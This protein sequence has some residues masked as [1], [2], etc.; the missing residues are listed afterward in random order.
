MK[1]LWIL[2]T[3]L[4]VA[5]FAGTLSAC[6]PPS[7]PQSS[8]DTKVDPG[9]AVGF[10]GAVS[11]LVLLDELHARRMA[12]MSTA[13]PEQLAQLKLTRDRLIRARDALQL[14]RNWLEGKTDSKE[15]MF[16]EAVAALELVAGELE[17]S[18]VALPGDV[19]SG[20][21]AARALAQV[22]PG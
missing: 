20:L 19:K 12:A 3:L 18:G 21:Q 9:V 17:A 4:V 1:T 6:P 10:A 11:A 13:T 16:R 15:A 22:N 5:I 7:P 2:V 14:V 8:G